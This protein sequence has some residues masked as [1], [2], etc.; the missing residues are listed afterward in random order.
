MKDYIIELK[1]VSKMYKMYE[2][3]HDMVKEALSIT[4]KKYHMEYYAIN[5]VSIQISRGEL[6]GIVGE[7]GAGKSTLLKLLTGV[8]QPTTGK[9]EVNGKISALLE[10]GAGFNP[11]YTGMENIFL[12]GVML[13]RTRKE[14]EEKVDDIVNFADI[15]EFINQPVKAYSSGMFARLAFAVAINVNPEILIVDE[16]LSVGDMRFQLKCVEKMQDL[17]EKGTTILFVSHDINILRRF[18]Q[19]GIWLNKGSINLVGEMNEVA[20]RYVDFLKGKN[21]IVSSKD[22][23]EIEDFSMEKLKKVDDSKKDCIAELVDV[24]VFDEFGV[25]VTTVNIN[26]PTKITLTYNVY[27]EKIENPVAGI[28]IYGADNEYICGLNTLLDK[29]K[30]SW[31]KGKNSVTLNYT[32]GLCLMGGTYYITAAV[33]DQTATVAFEYRDKF[34]KVVVKGGYPGEGKVIIPHHWDV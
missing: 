6:V 18:C 23:D 28:A 13:G 9:I 34:G 12:N 32:K 8:I 21:E 33:F 7:N 22:E 17:M 15:G 31:K 5:N 11:N 30:I 20:D 2:C 25:E 26:S 1:N 3:R 19:K 16:T 27:D 29:K 4:K 24:K 14:M 10:L